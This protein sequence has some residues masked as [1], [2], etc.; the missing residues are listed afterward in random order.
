LPPLSHEDDP[1]RAVK[2]A[3]LI[4]KKLQQIEIK[5]SIGVT[6]GKAFCGAVGSEERREYAMV[7]DIVN[8]S[9]RLMAKADGKVLVDNPTYT[10]SKNQL[11]FNTLAPIM[12]KGK[13]FPIEIYSP[14]KEAEKRTTS[15]RTTTLRGSLRFTKKRGITP[16]SGR[17]LSN[18]GRIDRSSM[19]IFGR[20]EELKQ[21][22]KEI[23]WLVRVEREKENSKDEE[24]E[25]NIED[26]HVILIEGQ[27][28]IGKTRLLQE[29][30]NSANDKK[31]KSVVGSGLAIEANTPY[32]AWHEIFT[33]ILNTEDMFLLTPQE[34]AEQINKTLEELG[35]SDVSE[36]APL[37]N[38]V[39][40]LDLPENA[41]T[42]QM[43]GQ[44]K[45][46]NLQVLLLRLLQASDFTM[47]TLENS[48]WLDSQSWS[49]TLAAAQ[50]LKGSLFLLAYR[51]FET[52]PP[53]DFEKICKLPT[54]K[55]IT[56]KNLDSESIKAIAAHRLGCKTL[57]VDIAQQVIERGGGEPLLSIELIDAL[58]ASGRFEVSPQ[59]EI[60]MNRKLVR[61]D[62]TVFPS[63]LRALI[64]SKVDRLPQS[65]QM[66]LKVAAVI[67]R[68]FPFDLLKDIM[69]AFTTKA[70]AQSIKADLEQLDSLDFI[71]L[72]SEKPLTYLFKQIMMQEVIYAQMLYA[73]RRQ[74]HEKV[75]EWYVNSK[76]D[77]TPSY[78]LLAHHYKQA[79]RWD[80]AI[81]YLAKAGEH[82]LD[83]FANREAVNFLNEAIELKYVLYYC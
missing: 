57:P 33:V 21:L 11:R 16:R 12:V 72:R 45:A 28:G 2:T 63:N 48:Q 31:I 60:I 70:D 54:A 36:L 34:K 14:V 19:P 50:T 53:L 71:S 52:E 35:I 40:G 65:Q 20:V 69:P 62:S 59:G 82:A 24:T 81:V 23:E 73:Q 83:S 6:T 67:G 79:E 13:N 77:Q 30:L 42:E 68:A 10:A 78:N 49:L 61:S 22:N 41:Q 3:L 5:S 15:G 43:S 51:P 44:V 27:A 18:M 25:D 46:E 58:R 55:K 76:Q 9:A 1:S 56:L 38:P 8:L 4:Q 17:S 37:L 32:Y 47:F 7:G 29:F 26:P 75:A 64:T 80:L 39:L 66:I 74:V